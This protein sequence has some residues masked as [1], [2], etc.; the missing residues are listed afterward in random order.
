VLSKLLEPTS[1]QVPR[2][3]LADRPLHPQSPDHHELTRHRGANSDHQRPTTYSGMYTQTTFVSSMWVATPGYVGQI[4]L[5]PHSVR[6]VE[7]IIPR[8]GLIVGQEQRRER[9]GDADEPVVLDRPQREAGCAN[10]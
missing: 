7:S 2:S 9:A 10:N 8:N 3:R 5:S 6:S 1:A 4:W